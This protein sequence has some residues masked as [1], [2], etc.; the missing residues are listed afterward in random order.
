MVVRASTR[1]T[2]YA[3]LSMAVVAASTT[4]AGRGAERKNAMVDMFAR[5]RATVSA[6]WASVSIQSSVVIFC[7]KVRGEIVQN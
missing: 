6:L 4:S 7:V 3:F 1:A 2:V 5:M